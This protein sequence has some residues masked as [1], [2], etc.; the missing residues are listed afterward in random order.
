MPRATRALVP[1]T[2]SGTPH[3]QV[4]ALNS[5]EPIESYRLS[6]TIAESAATS[7]TTALRREG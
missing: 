3:P 6:P 1:Q 5:Q 2:P 7:S 4:G